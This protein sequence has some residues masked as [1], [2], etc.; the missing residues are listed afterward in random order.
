MLAF[1]RKYRPK[2]FSDLVGQN[3]ITQTLKNAAASDKIAHSYLFYGPRGT[4]KTTTARI[5]AKVVNCQTRLE[6]KEFHQ[7]G[8]PCN[9]CKACEDIDRGTALD[10]IEIDAASNRGIDEIRTIKENIGLAPAYLTRKVFIIDETHMLTKEAFNALLKTLEEPP[11]HI[12]FVLATTEREKIPATIASRTQRFQFK[13][14]PINKISEKLKA[15]ALKE[16]IGVS[17]EALEVI[18]EASEGSLRDAESLLDQIV[19]F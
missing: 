6:N 2:S 5:L 7:N 13:K 1:Y 19:S 3:E 15:I 12:C 14:L 9:N 16:H 8:E 4:G 18:A 17:Q 10:V 11:Q